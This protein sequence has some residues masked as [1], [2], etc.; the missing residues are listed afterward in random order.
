MKSPLYTLLFAIIL[1]GCSCAKTHHINIINITEIGTYPRPL[2]EPL[3]ISVGV[4]YKEDFRTFET[5]QHIAIPDFRFRL[6][7][8]NIALF[9]YI[10]SH[11][12]EKVIP[13]K[14]FSQ[15]SKV[16]KDIDLIIEPTVDDYDYVSSVSAKLFLVPIVYAVTFYTPDGKRLGPWLIEGNGSEPIG[17]PLETTTTLIRRLTQLAMRQVAAKFMVGFCNQPEIKKLFSNQCNR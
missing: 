10:L 5:D 14:N 3:P 2:V 11:T 6:G 12:F 13:I 15:G 17:F 9:E 4:Y 8:A 7:E 16:T 1:L